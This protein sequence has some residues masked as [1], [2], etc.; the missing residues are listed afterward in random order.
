MPAA[1]NR[2]FATFRRYRDIEILT[3]ASWRTLRFHPPAG[4][5]ALNY[6]KIT[7]SAKPSLN[8][9]SLTYSEI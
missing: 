2:A 4:G 5:L 8:R 9:F 1:Q 6:D 7:G 3:S